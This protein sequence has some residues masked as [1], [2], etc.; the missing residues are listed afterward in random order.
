MSASHLPAVYAYRLVALQSGKNGKTVL[1]VA[2]EFER[3]VFRRVVGISGD[4]GIVIVMEACNIPIVNLHVFDFELG[5]LPRDGVVSRREAVVNDVS[6]L[7]VREYKVAGC[8]KEV[9]V[10]FF[11]GRSCVV[12]VGIHIA[13]ALILA[14][15][16]Q[17][18][19]HNAIDRTVVL[20][21]YYLL[22]FRIIVL[23]T[24]LYLHGIA[25]GDANHILGSTVVTL[26]ECPEWVIGILLVLVGVIVIDVLLFYFLIRHAHEA[27]VLL[28]GSSRKLAVSVMPRGIGLVI[29]VCV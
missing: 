15:V 2:I 8:L 21:F 10:F 27:L 29:E 12:V 6:A 9:F 20:L 11:S 16:Y 23:L 14:D 22:A 17:V 26:L 19:L 25:G 3:I 5:I 18:H 7:M 24:E 4:V 1:I 28:V 13:A